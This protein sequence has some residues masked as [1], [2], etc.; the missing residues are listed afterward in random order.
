MWLDQAS[1]LQTLDI[2]FAIYMHIYSFYK[3]KYVSIT[4]QDQDTGNE[5][6]FTIPIPAAFYKN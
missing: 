2:L 1:Y 5:S 4:V 3:T 6:F